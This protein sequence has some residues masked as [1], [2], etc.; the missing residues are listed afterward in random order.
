VGAS[1]MASRRAVAEALVVEP[2]TAVE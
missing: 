1:L 2:G